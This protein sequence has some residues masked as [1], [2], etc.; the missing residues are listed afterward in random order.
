MKFTVNKK[1]YTSREFDFNLICELE[2]LG[3]EIEKLASKPMSGVR[4]YFAL[5]A[6]ISLAEAGAEFNQHIIDG[7]SMDGVTIAMTKALEES[8]FFRALSKD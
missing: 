8:G 7:G 4:A 2:E 6:G 5:C 3:I 1:D